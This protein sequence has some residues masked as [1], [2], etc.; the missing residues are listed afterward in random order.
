MPQFSLVG[1][2]DTLSDLSFCKNATYVVMKVS[3]G[4]TFWIILTLCNHAQLNGN[5]K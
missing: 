2:S 3:S 1:Y 5:W 4:K